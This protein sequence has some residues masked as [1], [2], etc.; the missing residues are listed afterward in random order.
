MSSSSDE[1]ITP[2]SERPIQIKQKSR[3]RKEIVTER[4]S[5]SEDEQSSDDTSRDEGEAA[6]DDE[7]PVLSH[8]EQRRQK[9]KQKKTEP[10]SQPQDSTDDTS[11]AKKTQKIKNTAEL[12]PSKV[13][14]RQ[15]SVWIGN[16]SFKTTPDVLRRFF[17]GVGEIT[18]VHMPMK[19]ASAGPGGKG[20][21]KEN[22]GLVRSMYLP[23]VM[24]IMYTLFRPLDLRMWT[25]R[26]PT[27]K[28]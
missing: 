2:E 13:P 8:A 24:E 25:L 4:S 18:R 10:T 21:V 28:M 19:M 23:Y 17:D 22:R 7:V 6:Q 20:A 14:K 26:L 9:K 27:P 12:A 11:K 16:L 15:N 3:K 5:D 1:S